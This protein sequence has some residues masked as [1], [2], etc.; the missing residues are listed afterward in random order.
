MSDKPSTLRE[1]VKFSAV[2]GSPNCG[3]LHLKR[4][5]TSRYCGIFLSVTPNLVYVGNMRRLRLK[6]PGMAIILIGLFAYM[7]SAADAHETK[8]QEALA[9]RIERCKNEGGIPSPQEGT[10][11]C[12]DPCDVKWVE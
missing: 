1:S 5:T 12:L 6:P 10:V 8:K 7:I 2:T 3:A 4:G 11:T 9:Q